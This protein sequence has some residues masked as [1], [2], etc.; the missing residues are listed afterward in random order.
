MSENVTP[1]IR[2]GSPTAREVYLC[3]GI[4]LSWWEASE[5]M[6]EMLF[7]H[8]CNMKEPIAMETFRVAPRPARVAMIKSALKHH[9]SRVTPEE[10]SAVLDALRKLERLSSTRNE[11]AHGHVSQINMTVN[12]SVT[13]RG[14]F[15][16]STLNPMGITTSREAN[17]KYAHTAAE[18]DKWSE[19][20]RHERGRIMDVWVAIVTRDQ[21]GQRQ[22]EV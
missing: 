8:L 22:V 6:L 4:A 2:E 5:D 9:A 20:V 18:I 11:I 16:A 13:M 1:K 12:D 14:N 7:V 15:L 10:T 3:V 19:K 17:T 21:E